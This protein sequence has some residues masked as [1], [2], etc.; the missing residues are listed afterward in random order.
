M[1]SKAYRRFRNEREI[2]KIRLISGSCYVIILLAFYVLKIVAHD[3]CF[4]A[5]TYAF[6]LLGTYEMLRAMKDKT[7]KAQKGIV[8]AF[9]IVTIPAC[10]LC[11]QFVGL[12]LQVTLIC[13]FAL[14]VALLS[15]LVIRHEETTP[16]NLGVS[17][18]SA[19]YPT[20]LLCLLVLSNHV[21]GSQEL[22][23]YALDSRVMILFIFVVSPVSDSLAYVFGRFLRKYFPKKMA[24]KI[25]PNK[26]VIGGIGGIVGGMLGA[27][28]LY[29]A[30]NAAVG[31]FDHMG[32]WLPVY[33][34]IGLFAAAA[35]EFGDLVESCIKRK[36]D[37][38]DM[39]KIM[40]G[41]GGALDRIDGTLFATTVVYVAFTL[42]HVIA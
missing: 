25:S 36:V 22:A 4:D 12:G 34:V 33:L 38:K 41:H 35:T 23:K 30:Y 29:F 19:V 6:A 39:G 5:L 1:R 17:F 31:S 2:M 26:T 20:L 9:A 37:I 14:S 18:L 16:E 32:L 15:L 8:F 28:I 10:A 42:I 3:L 13:L 27:A 21:N 7:T 24:P 11:E 40:P